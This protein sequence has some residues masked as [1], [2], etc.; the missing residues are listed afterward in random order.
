MASCIAEWKPRIDEAMRAELTHTGELDREASPSDELMLALG[1]APGA[2]T[3]DAICPLGLLAL[4]MMQDDIDPEEGIKC[5]RCGGTKPAPESTGGFYALR[6]LL[7]VK[8]RLQLECGTC[9][10]LRACEESVLPIHAQAFTAEHTIK[11]DILLEHMY[12]DAWT[13]SGGESEEGEEED[14]SENSLDD[15]P[16][17]GVYRHVA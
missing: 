10:A 15:V 16:L 14:E 5:H 11:P 7:D 1:L 8:P 4:A 6:Q 13:S 3:P 9:H 2:P 17:G 12:N